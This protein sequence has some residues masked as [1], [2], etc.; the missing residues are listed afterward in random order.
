MQAENVDT[1][2]KQKAQQPA[3]HKVQKLLK[4]AKAARTYSNNK[5][6]MFRYGPQCRC[7]HVFSEIRQNMTDLSFS[8]KRAYALSPLRTP[9]PNNA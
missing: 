7:T 3:L 1:S 9:A 6:G 5:S 4:L 8:K 2:R